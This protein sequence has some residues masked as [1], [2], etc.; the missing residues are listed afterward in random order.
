MCTDMIE[1]L[2]SRN[3][4]SQ[5]EDGALCLESHYGKARSARQIIQKF[6]DESSG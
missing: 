3:P 6:R 4:Q 5:K 2:A 1:V